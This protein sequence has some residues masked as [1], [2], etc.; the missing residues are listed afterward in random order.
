MRVLSWPRRIGQALVFDLARITWNLWVNVIGGSVLLPRPVRLLVY[1][2]A[3]LDIHTLNV[4]PGCTFT[5]RNVH[6]G[7]GSFLNLR[8]TF[9]GGPVW[10]GERCQIGPESFWATAYHAIDEHGL[11]EWKFERRGIV[12]GDDALVS[13]R[14]FVSPGVRIAPG[15]TV[16][17]GAIVTRDLEV[18]GLYAGI[19]ARLVRR[20]GPDADAN[21]ADG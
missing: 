8:V 2:I 13:T 11:S 1:R 15:C 12:V 21:D 18:Q 5:H 9:E 17:P 6:I 14:V 20:L 19:P 4:S 7:N 16:A 3:G 10:I